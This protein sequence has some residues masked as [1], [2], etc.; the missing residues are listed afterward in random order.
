MATAQKAKQIEELK[1]KFERAVGIVQAEYRG[2]GAATM[3]KLR[4]ELRR[5]NVELKVIKNRLARIAAKG[6][7]AEKLSE[8]FKGPISLAFGYDNPVAPAKILAE[9]AKKEKQFLIVGGMA[10]G[11]C[12]NGE[13][14]RKIGSLPDKNTLLS[15]MLR[16]M[17]GPATNFVSVLDG[18]LRKFVFLLIALKQEKDQNP[19]SKGGQE[20]S[21]LSAEDVKS[22]LNN[23]SVLKLVEFTKELEDEWGVTAAVAVA[24]AAP[25]GGGAVAEAEEQT[26]FTV[27]ITAAGDK[28]IQ[29][30]KAVR[31]ATGLGLKEAKA[32]VD[33]APKEVKEKISKED[34]D[35]LKA[36]LE[37]AGASVEIK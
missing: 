16:T 34:A 8:N 23:L 9:F 22:F 29:V 27:M 36:K 12:Y 25:A 17:Q 37:E 3:D 2:L 7:N 11:E 10:E 15:M 32:V 1:E 30:I 4:A 6:T 20:M 14:M 26:E 5:G 31:E 21:D 18:V 13:Q 19:E 28:K 35:A 33:A 24:S